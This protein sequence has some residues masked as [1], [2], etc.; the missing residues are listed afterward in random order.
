[1]GQ[2][3]AGCGVAV[4]SGADTGGGAHPGRRRVSWCP[5]VVESGSRSLHAVGFIFLVQYEVGSSAEHA[6]LRVGNLKKK[7]REILC[8]VAER[9][10]LASWSSW[11]C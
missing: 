6:R 3:S 2:V 1:M 4:R 7:D 9:V 11:D 5:E 10:R 8:P